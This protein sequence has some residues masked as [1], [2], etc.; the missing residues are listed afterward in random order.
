[1]ETA[2]QW[3]EFL[4]WLCLALLMV[5]GTALGILLMWR[6]FWKDWR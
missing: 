6:K 2:P 3:F 1:M 5:S 4:K